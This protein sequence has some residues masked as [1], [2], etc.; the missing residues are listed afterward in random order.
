MS[1]KIIITGTTG[2]VG[3]GVLLACLND[4][5]IEEIL[6][7]NRKPCGYVHSKIKEIIH[8]DFFNLSAIENE[9]K[10]YQACFFCLGITSVGTHQEV[11]YK[12]TYT[13]TMHVAETLSK[14]NPELTFCYISGSGTNANGRL[15]WAQVKGKTEL[16]L[17]K[18]PFKQV[19]NLRPG[20]IKPLPEQRYAHKFYNYIGWLYPI[21]RAF[22]PNGFCTMKEL[23]A[24]MKNTLHTK[25]VRKILEGKDII[26]LA[27]LQD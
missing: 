1:D 14:L 26:A 23:A 22:F 5:R 3:E 25:N 21:G 7:L 15:K 24:A 6:L 16:D 11:Y 19:Y 18:L 20:F 27:K 12:T 13:L 10:G 17:M 8:S 2:M 4:A 9:L